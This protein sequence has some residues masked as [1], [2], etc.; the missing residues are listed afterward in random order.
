MELC[1]TNQNP[2]CMLIEMFII[3]RM[4]EVQWLSRLCKQFWMVGKLC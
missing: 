3:G 4:W 2:N 1:E